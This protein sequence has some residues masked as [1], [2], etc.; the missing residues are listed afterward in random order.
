MLQAALQV[1]TARVVDARTAA[2]LEGLAS[3]Y[4]DLARDGAWHSPARAGIDACV[5]RV[6]AP[7]TG[8]VTLVIA[9][10]RIERDA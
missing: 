10:G 8:D 5:D 7:A 2:L 1:I 3:A 9:Q 4:A 6:L